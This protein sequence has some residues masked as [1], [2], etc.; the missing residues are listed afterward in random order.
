MLPDDEEEIQDHDEQTKTSL[1]HGDA[2]HSSNRSRKIVMSKTQELNDTFHHMNELLRAGSLEELDHHSV[3]CARGD[4][5]C[6]RGDR[7]ALL[8]MTSSPRH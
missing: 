1:R 3:I 6:L 5:E 8:P 4:E 7:K 2:T